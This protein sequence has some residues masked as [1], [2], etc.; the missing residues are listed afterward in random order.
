LRADRDALR[1][2]VDALRG[3][4]GCCAECERLNGVIDDIVAVSGYSM[5]IDDEEHEP[6]PLADLV[7][8]I[9]SD[10]DGAVLAL[11]RLRDGCGVVIF[12]SDAD[13]VEDLLQRNHRTT[14]DETERVVDAGSLPQHLA[15]A[16]NSLRWFHQWHDD[17]GAVLWFF[18]P[19]TEPPFHVGTPFDSDWP[20]DRGREP[21][22]DIIWCRL[23]KLTSDR[24]AGQGGHRG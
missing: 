16:E 3:R 24:P 2:E 5:F 15:D 19:I 21:Q 6:P 10:R 23:P 22:S 12:G 17:D 18:C 8:S 13:L 14:S 1:A 7:A 11:R 20:W 4:T 9:V